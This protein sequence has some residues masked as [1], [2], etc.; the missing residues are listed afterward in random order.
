MLALV[1]DSHPS[2]R[3]EVARSLNALVRYR[4]GRPVT[5]DRVTHTHTYPRSLGWG[6]S[7]RS[8]NHTMR[9][10]HFWC[11]LHLNSS[12]GFR[13]S[14]ATTTRNTESVARIERHTIH[15]TCA[16]CQVFRPER[17]TRLRD[18]EAIDRTDTSVE[19]NCI[20]NSD[21]DDECGRAVRVS[22]RPFFTSFSI[23]RG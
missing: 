8:R 14:A 12:S 21:D 1:T 11:R 9:G 22:N 7:R 6:A 5:G 3:E 16:V 23:H 20:Y 15:L 10:V 13:P 19:T 17:S 2:N 18:D 4:R